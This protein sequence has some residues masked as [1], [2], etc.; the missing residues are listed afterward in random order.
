[1]DRRRDPENY[2]HLW[3]K[4]LREVKDELAE[5]GRPLAPQSVKAIRGLLAGFDPATFDEVAFVR[6]EMEADERVYRDPGLR[7]G[8]V[9]TLEQRVADFR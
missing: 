6:A 1:V 5:T 9:A 2:A 8:L 7:A 4:P 3:G